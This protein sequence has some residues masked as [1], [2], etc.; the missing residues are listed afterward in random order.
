MD[1]I[2]KVDAIRVTIPYSSGDFFGPDTSDLGTRTI[3]VTIPYSSG[4]FFG[5]D[6]EC[7]AD[8]DQH[9]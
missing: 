3:L 5:R 9:P 8:P 2:P 4:D 7:D 6:S 1:R